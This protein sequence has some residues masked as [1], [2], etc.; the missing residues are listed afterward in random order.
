MVLK[1]ESADGICRLLGCTSSQG[2]LE[3]LTIG[4]GLTFPV[5]QIPRVMYLHGVSTALPQIDHIA[6]MKK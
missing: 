1:G 6:Q 4:R 3:G 5:L 2:D